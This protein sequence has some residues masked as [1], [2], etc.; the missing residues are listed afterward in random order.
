MEGRRIVVDG[1]KSESSYVYSRVVII[2]DCVRAGYGVSPLWTE[3]S[4]VI[5]ECPWAMTLCSV[6]GGRLDSHI[7]G[8]SC[9]LPDR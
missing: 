3:T 8:Y 5:P 6:D 7:G 4:V 2:A 9:F 1:A